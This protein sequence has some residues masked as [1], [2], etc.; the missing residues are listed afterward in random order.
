MM[1]ILLAVIF[2]VALIATV[3]A[4]AY[5]QP[6]PTPM[7]QL[8]LVT[9]PGT[10]YTFN[11]WTSDDSWLQ[12]T[13]GPQLTEPFTISNQQVWL[14]GAI[15]QGIDLAIRVLLHKTLVCQV[16]GADQISLARQMKLRILADY[17]DVTVARATP[18]SIN[19]ILAALDAGC[20]IDDLPPE[21]ETK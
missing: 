21:K 12:W 14:Q 1:R 7:P 19:A 8:P 2:A 4:W 10:S 20:T 9:Q 16:P 15:L 5:A 18:A 17:K 3:V 6:E 13:P 11:L